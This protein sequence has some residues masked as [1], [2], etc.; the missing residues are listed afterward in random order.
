V[1]G[2]QPRIE[3]QR[4]AKA[5]LRGGQLIAV[6]QTPPKA[7]MRL[8]KS[9][10]QFYGAPETRFGLRRSS[11]AR[12]KQAQ[13]VLHAGGFRIA[14]DRPPPETFRLCKIAQGLSARGGNF[15]QSGLVMQFDRESVL[16][17]AQRLLRQ[18]A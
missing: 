18:A 7:E 10:L 6:G 1:R 2:R 12:Q 5:L 11:G 9:R 3:S 4:P 17:D 15:A 8:R 16:G 13:T 14:G